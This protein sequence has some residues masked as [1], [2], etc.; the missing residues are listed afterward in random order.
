MPWVMF[1]SKIGIKQ[2]KVYNYERE[3][4]FVCQHIAHFIDLHDW[5]NSNIHSVEFAIAVF[6][7]HCI[8]DYRYKVWE[9]VKFIEEMAKRYK[10]EKE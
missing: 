1:R 10:Q 7:Y 8:C 3:I 4:F 6:I 5:Q 9:S 2:E